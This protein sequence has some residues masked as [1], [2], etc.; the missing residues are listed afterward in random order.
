MKRIWASLAAWSWL[1]MV[2]AHAEQV[3]WEFGPENLSQGGT[4]SGSLVYDKVFGQAPFWDIE[5]TDG[6]PPF[7]AFRYQSG[8]L[9]HQAIGPGIG[10]GPLRLQSGAPEFRELVLQVADLPF[11][12]GTARILVTENVVVQ[13][14]FADQVLFTGRG[15]ATVT[16]MDVTGVICRAP[17]PV[18]YGDPVH[19]ATGS[20]TYSPLLMEGSDSTVP[21][22]FEV[23]Y[24][25]GA[26]PRASAVGNKWR[27]SYDWTVEG[28]DSNWV[29]VVQG[30]RAA[31]YF[32]AQDD[33][34]SVTLVPIYPQSRAKL[35]VVGTDRLVYTTPERMRYTFDEDGR[36]IAVADPSGRSAQ[37]SYDGA[38]RLVSFVEP[39][40]ASRTATFLY[41]GNDRIV[42]I[43]YGTGPALRGVNLT[44]DDAGNLESFSSPQNAQLTARFSYDGGSRLLTGTMGSAPSNDV[45]VFTNTYDVDGRVASQRD[46]GGQTTTF[47]YI[48]NVATVT[49]PL[50]VASTRTFDDSGRLVGATDERGSNYSWSYDDRGNL[51]DDSGPR[52]S[53]RETSYD[54]TTGNV[55]G[56]TLET[57]DSLGLTWDSNSY[58]TSVAD[59]NGNARTYTYDSAGNVTGY[60]NALGNSVQ[61]QYDAS[62][63]RT[64]TTD[65]TGIATTY[66]YDAQGQLASI[67][68]AGAT[69]DFGYDGYGNPTSYTDPNGNTT[70]LTVDAAGAIGSIT[71]GSGVVTN[72]DND[73]FG[74]V[75]TETRPDGRSVT[76]ERDAAG[77]V[78]A[79]VDGLGNRYEYAYDAAGRLASKTDPRGTATGYVYAARGQLEQTTDAL[80]NVTRATYTSAGQQL[81]VADPN[82][83]TTTFTYD[84]LGRIESETDPLAR[85]TLTEY[86]AA[87]SATRVTNRRGQ[88]ITYEYDAAGSLTAANLPGDTVTY[89]VDPEGRR[90]SSMHAAGTTTVVYDNALGRVAERTDEH[91]N[92]IRYGYDS[93]GNMTT[94]TYSDGSTVTYTYDGAGRMTSVRDWADRT[95]TY[96][97]DSGGSLASTTLPDG[98]TVAYTYDVAGRLTALSTEDSGGAAIYSGQYTYDASGRT[99]TADETLPLSPA[100][101]A[102]MDNFSY[103]AAD[104]IIALNGQSFG[105]D[106]D[107]NL[108]SGMIGGATV[109]L[110]Y[111]ALNRLVQR[112]D[113]VYTYDPDNFRIRAT[114]GGVTTRYVWDGISRR[115]RLL[116]EQDAGGTITARYVHGIGLIS[117]ED[118]ASGDLSVYH[119]DPRGS[120]VALTNAAGAVTDR[121]AYD[122]YGAV[123]GRQGSTPNPFTYNGRDGVFDDGDGFYYM[124]ARYYIP[125]LGRFAQQEPL[126]RG[127]LLR[128]QSLNRYAFAEGNPIDRIDPRGE[129]WS[130]FTAAVGAVVSVGAQ[131]VSNAIDG[132]PF[133]EDIAGAAVK[134][135][136]TGAAVSLG[137]WG[138]AAAGAVGGALGDLVDQGINIA[139]GRQNSIDMVSVGTD[140]A[141][142]AAFGRFSGR[143]PKPGSAKHVL[144][145][146]SSGL[147]TSATLR[148]AG[149]WGGK[150]FGYGVV[151]N[152]GESRIAGTEFDPRTWNWQQPVDPFRSS[153]VIQYNMNRPTDGCAPRRGRTITDMWGLGPVPS[154]GYL[155]DG[156][157]LVPGYPL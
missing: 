50:G 81:T 79:T 43:A 135:A 48:G 148:A 95:T 146:A 21:F 88:V 44:Y 144:K 27:H 64:M 83:S 87:G 141:F 14:R 147:S 150:K 109:A 93:V 138:Q 155:T 36:L 46:G 60:T 3:A 115:L 92:T 78:T 136:I 140:F 45:A 22:T 54:P 122:P 116:E 151:L 157:Y 63:R 7:T 113:D 117:R 72:L 91:G 154:P 37:L 94:L 5:V 53:L 71:D 130:V 17:R 41:D 97:Y 101:S 49:D 34:S 132:K 120:T 127:S 58:L 145:N 149:R 128:P 6:A 84:T 142:G 107:G 2:P 66:S 156:A 32:N 96:S 56:I 119:Y 77:R 134:G 38:D 57:G 85:E 59:G 29:T 61:Y 16:P 23:H 103:D 52:E 28:L 110:T 42:S 123:A 118:A 105:Y 153:H 73:V 31:D 76:F 20:F 13:S 47:T 4:I 82:G 10:N 18:Y 111:D 12:A 8:S 35:E 152:Q 137:P 24:D 26:E 102:G 126:Y 74:R 143:T 114:R 80:G 70:S 11:T 99:Q 90:T 108:T 39:A 133:Y 104:Q 131:V 68:R 19:L 65:A 124:T 55:T 129:L 106:Q 62:G 139:R 125:S 9:G 100:I 15:L 89:T 86:D 112:N 98:S 75:T 51:A 25:S 33:G 69:I 40:P 67:S 30:N 121:Y 1:L